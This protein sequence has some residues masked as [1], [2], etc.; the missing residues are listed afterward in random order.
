[1]R[2]NQ[3]FFHFN[4]PLSF[5]LHDLQRSCNIAALHRIVQTITYADVSKKYKNSEARSRF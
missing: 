1:M 4:R 3:P 2:S 5:P